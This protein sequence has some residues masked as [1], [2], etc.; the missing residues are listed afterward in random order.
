MEKRPI[1]LSIA[2]YDATA[3]AGLLADI[4]TF[5]MHRVY[6]MG[7]VSGNTFQTD[8]SFTGVN[9]IGTGDILRQLNL[10]LENY[11]INFV[12]IGIIENQKVLSEIVSRLRANNPET[13]IVWDPVLK[14]S[15]GFLFHERDGIDL[16]FVTSQIDLITPNW[17]EYQSLHL[18]AVDL[19]STRCSILLKGGHRQ[20]KEGTDVLITGRERIEIV[21]KPFG[22]K[23]KHGTGCVLS[24]AILAQIALGERLETACKKAKRYTENLILSNE[25]NLGYHF[26]DNKVR[27]W[28]NE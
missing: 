10:L 6:G 13:F 2:G 25:T 8:Y 19:T 20:D 18:E 15:S 4:K 3:G 16:D 7:V 14:S 9:W 24:A 5:E 1:V 26:T 27:I 28:T 22:N 17:I 21:G 11:E 23:S 12:K